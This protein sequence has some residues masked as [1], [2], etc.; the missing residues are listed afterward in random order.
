M[1]KWIRNISIT[2]L[3]AM[4]MC[5][6][7]SQAMASVTTPL[8]TTQKAISGKISHSVSAYGKVETTQE[9]S[10]AVPTQRVVEKV[11]IQVGDRVEMGEA[12]FQLSENKALSDAE[13]AFSTWVA[14]AYMTLET[15]A[16]AYLTAYESWQKYLIKTANWYWKSDADHQE[17]NLEEAMRAEQHEYYAA[18][19]DYLEI[20]RE[21]Q[22]KA[23]EDSGVSNGGVKQARK[24]VADARSEL[25]LAKASFYEYQ[26]NR[27]KTYQYTRTED[28][29]KLREALEKAIPEYENALTGFES[30]LA[31]KSKAVED[32]SDDLTTDGTVYAKASGIVKEI[33]LLVGDQTGTTAAAVL[34]VDSDEKKVTVKVPSEYEEYITVG[35]SVTLKKYGEKDEIQGAQVKDIQYNKE[36]ASLLEITITVTDV[37][38]VLGEQVEVT[39][40]KQTEQYGMLVPTNAVYSENS[41]N[42]VLIV[43]EAEG[44][45]GTVLKAQK[46]SVEILD[47]NSRYAAISAKEAKDQDIISWSDR[48][49]KDGCRVR[50]RVL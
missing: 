13:E 44:I 23:I 48:E 20:Y 42:Y 1:K 32:A 10:V 30:D 16:D 27:E 22:E 31:E 41:E 24:A 28:E 40:D 11:Y 49:V 43:R 36:D 3:A 14:K 12:L 39:F 50:K 33:K 46:V 7:L 47:K 8:V 21:W 15:A 45:L 6:F 2:F 26:R 38:L 17:D 4:I 35:D 5:T 29:N 19:K 18:Y 34:S 9:V 37:T 25:Q